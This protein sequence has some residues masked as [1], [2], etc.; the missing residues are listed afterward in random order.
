VNG[1]VKIQPFEVV[2]TAGPKA[3]FS[4]GVAAGFANAKPL[5]GGGRILENEINKPVRELLQQVMPADTIPGG[6]GSGRGVLS[7]KLARRVQVEGWD[8]LS[9]DTLGDVLNELDA[10]GFEY[11][12]NVR[13]ETMAA[14]RTKMLGDVAKD[15]AEQQEIMG[16]AGFVGPFVG[17]LGAEFTD[18]V[19]LATL[20]IGAPSRAGLALT[21]AIEASINAGLE[22]GQTP[23][24][25]RLL[26]ELGEPEE[27]IAE[28]ALLGAIF[29]A[30]L[31]VAVRGGV[32]AGKLALQAPQAVRK[33]LAKSAE[34]SPSPAAQQAAETILKDLDDEVAAIVT[35]DPQ[36]R[37]EHSGRSQEAAKAVAEG[38]VPDMPERPLA[39]PPRS[40]GDTSE[41]VDPRSL[42]VEPEVFQFKSEIVADGGVTAKLK[43]VTEWVPHRAGV[44]IVYE[45]P[46]GSRSIADGHQRVALA[47]RI[48]DPDIRL[49]AEIFR[50]DDGFSVDDIRTLAALKNIAE[51]SDGLTGKL[52]GDAAKVLRIDPNAVAQLP[53]GPGITRAKRLTALSDDA[54]DLYINRVVDERFAEKV[55]EMVD[56]PTLHAPIMRLL[57]RVRPETTEQASNVIT[58]ALEA[59]T[60]REVTADLFGEREVVESL[61]LEQAKVLERALKILREDRSVFKTLTEQSGQIETTGKNR[62]DR[63]T[64]ADARQ[65]TEEALVAIKAQA[66]RAGPVS[67]ALRDGAKS[68]KETGRLKDAAESLAQV[69]RREVERDGLF[70]GGAGTRGQPAQS[71]GART[72]PPD[73]NDGFSDPV[74]PA[75]E[76]QVAQ[77]R[78][79]P[80]PSDP[81]DVVPVG[82]GFDD[83]GNEI[84]QTMTRA[85]LAEEL[86]AEDEFVEQLGLCLK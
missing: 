67:E 36:D 73:P 30:T 4:E 71:T 19:N 5:I 25:N 65:Q 35:N 51:A 33:A 56:D 86:D 66:H 8:R 27:S 23:A 50:E 78:I 12:E 79:D 53:K 18:P 47:N 3:T 9:D 29:G 17:A 72:E 54:F 1:L 26:A 44:A 10:I 40:S 58:Q 57:E 68:Y 82:R 59:P 16:R 74:G 39:T 11:S 48:G 37:A 69:V 49:R 60:S 22:A 43:D 62:L 85:E 61:Y 46:D 41:L 42:K 34:N 31:P 7:K 84:A 15:R 28:N 38:R 83:E 24:R 6:T 64:N 52:A 76:A 14:R 77:T 32:E 80:E 63:Q 81:L 13:P 45:Y 55:G 20:P 70:G 2:P 75:A 21:V